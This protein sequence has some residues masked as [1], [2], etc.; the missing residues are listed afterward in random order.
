MVAVS[1][2][3]KKN[4]DMSKKISIRVRMS[5][6]IIEKNNDMSRIISIY[7]RG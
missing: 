1:F 6:N 2:F 3:A 5:Y 7:Y 4:N